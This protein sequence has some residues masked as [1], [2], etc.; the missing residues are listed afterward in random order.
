MARLLRPSNGIKLRGGYYPPEVRRAVYE[1]H[2]L[3]A[4]PGGTGKPYTY[5]VRRSL[6]MR[7]IARGRRATLPWRRLHDDSD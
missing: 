3:L 4:L 2:D 6:S 5:Y 1:G 7:D